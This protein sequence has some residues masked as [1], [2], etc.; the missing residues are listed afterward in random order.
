MIDEIESTITQLAQSAAQKKN[1]SFG[2]VGEADRYLANL[3]HELQLSAQEGSSLLVRGLA[4]CAE[5]NEASVSRLCTEL[6][7]HVDQ[8]SRLTEIINRTVSCGDNVIDPFLAAM[9]H[10]YDCGDFEKEQCVIAVLLALFPLHPQP[11]VYLGTLIWRK[12]GT[13]AAERFYSKIVTIIED[14]ALDYFAADFFYQKGS[15]NQAKNLL[16]RALNNCEKSPVMYCD[17]QGQIR[18]LLD[19]CFLQ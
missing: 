2:S 6:L 10:F 5:L 4:Y 18:A 17:L 11:Y 14:P 12:D 16:L 19:Q 3:R 7:N 9:N 1:L 8:P 15:P 13:D